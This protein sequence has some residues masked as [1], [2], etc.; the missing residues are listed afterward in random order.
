MTH[1]LW[2]QNDMADY[3][4]NGEPHMKKKSELLMAS[5]SLTYNSKQQM[6]AWVDIVQY[7]N[8]LYGVYT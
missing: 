5:H 6:D 7:N 1:N 2:P 8:A 4:R 3:I